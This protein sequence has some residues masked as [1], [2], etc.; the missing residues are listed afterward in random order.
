MAI[1]SY[2]MNIGVLQVQVVLMQDAEHRINVS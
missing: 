2:E 1:P